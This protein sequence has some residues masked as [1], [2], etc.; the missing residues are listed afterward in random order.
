MGHGLA[1]CSLF[2]VFQKRLLETLFEL[3]DG[4]LSSRQTKFSSI[5]RQDQIGQGAQSAMQQDSLKVVEEA[6]GKAQV[7]LAFPEE[8]LDFP[9][10][11]DQAQHCD[12]FGGQVGCY[13]KVV[14][15][16]FSFPLF[17]ASHDD[18]DS[19]QDFMSG[20]ESPVMT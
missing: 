9:S 10:F 18:Q 8:D 20:E 4:L 6:T 17:T 11:L 14:G 5:E 1:L 19:A 2:E 7:L 3:S 15:K 12:G 16:V 13:Q